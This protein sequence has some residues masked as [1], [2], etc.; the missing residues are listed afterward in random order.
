MFREILLYPRVEVQ[1]RLRRD[2]LGPG[3]IAIL[4]TAMLWL[5][6]GSPPFGEFISA[7]AELLQVLAGFYIAL[8]ALVS[9]MPSDSLDKK[10]GID[11]VMIGGEPAKLKIGTGYEKLTRRRYLALLFG[12]LAFL[13]VSLYVLGVGSLVVGKQIAPALG[14]PIPAITTAI[15][16]ITL[17]LFTTYAFVVSH[18]FS[19]TAN[20]VRYLAYRLL[21]PETKQTLLTPETKQS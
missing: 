17:V 20:G 5:L 11:K 2:Y 9:T 7:I 13:C 6:P 15:T 8:L 12:Y 19:I 10:T 3:L 1:G 14:K 4:L 21:T 16:A 18:M